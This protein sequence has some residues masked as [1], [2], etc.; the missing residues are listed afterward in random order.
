MTIIHKL[1]DYN[2]FSFKSKRMTK[3]EQ[4]RLSRLVMV[5]SILTFLITLPTAIAHDECY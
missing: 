4:K 1:I 2:L 3:G 5:I